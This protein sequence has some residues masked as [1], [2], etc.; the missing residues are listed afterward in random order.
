MNTVYF[1][2]DDTSGKIITPGEC[3]TGPH[4]RRSLLLSLPLTLRQKLWHPLV[5]GFSWPLCVQLPW[6]DQQSCRFSAV[7]AATAVASE[8]FVH[9]YLMSGLKERRH[10]VQQ[11]KALLSLN[12]RLQGLLKC[13]SARG[14]DVNSPCDCTFSAGLQLNDIQLNLI[15]SCFLWTGRVIL[16]S[17]KGGVRLYKIIQ[18]LFAC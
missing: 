11:K 12:V 16:S 18:M 7:A 8:S 6:W 15:S 1:I 9:Q 5:T 13:F 10:L 4:E 3:D 2:H 17:S 14:E